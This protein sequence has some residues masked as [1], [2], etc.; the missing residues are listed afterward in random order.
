MNSEVRKNWAGSMT[1]SAPNFFRPKTVQEVQEVV[2][3]CNTLKVLGS[4]CTFSMISDNSE[5]QI[6][7]QEMNKVVSLDK[8]NHTVTVEGGMRYGDLC[9]YLHSNGYALHNLAS[10]PHIS[11]AGACA[12]A[13]HGSGVK[14]GSLPTAVAAIEFVDAAG[15]VINISKEKNGDDFYG[16]VVALGGMGVITKTTLNLLPTFDM[17]QVVYENLPMESLKKHFMDIVSAGYSVSLFTDWRNKNVSQ[18]WIKH[19]VGKEGPKTFPLEL[20]GAK[21][22]TRQRHPVDDVYAPNCTDQLGV[23]APWWQRT[24]HFKMEFRPSVGAELQSEHFVPIEHAYEAIMALESIHDKTSPHLFISEIRTVKADDFWM[25]PCYKRDSIGIHYTWKQEI[26][27]VQPLI[28]LIE[29]KLAPFRPRPHLGKLFNMSPAKL[30]ANYEKLPEFKKLL[31]KYDP[32]GKFRRGFIEDHLYLVSELSSAQKNN[33]L[34]PKP[35]L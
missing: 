23:P 16:A 12:T 2:K 19:K 10:L 26:E 25:S 28:T 11:I 4:A 18:V 1:Y 31:K 3:K 32:Q 24:A 27:A 35:K 6:S 33:N 5:N 15:D 22:A 14:N 17:Q 13:S 20:Y 9:E 8:I 29:E 7:L 34:Q 21:L 30:Q